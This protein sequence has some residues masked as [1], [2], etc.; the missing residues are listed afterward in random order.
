MTTTTPFHIN[1]T[2]RNTK[3]LALYNW[4]LSI[5]FPPLKAYQIAK[6]KTMKLYPISPSEPLY[7]AN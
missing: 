2:V 1:D 4:W 3:F 6:A 5:Q 7:R